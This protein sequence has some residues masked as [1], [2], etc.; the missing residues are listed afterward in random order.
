MSNSIFKYIVWSRNRRLYFPP[1]GFLAARLQL[2]FNQESWQEP[3][4]QFSINGACRFWIAFPC[5]ECSTAELLLLCRLQLQVHR[6]PPASFPP[7]EHDLRQTWA[8]TSAASSFYVESINVQPKTLSQL[9]GKIYT[10]CMSVYKCLL[11]TVVFFF[12]LP[13]KYWLF[14]TKPKITLQQNSNNSG[15]W[16]LCKNAVECWT[17]FLK[18]A[19]KSG[20]LFLKLKEATC[21]PQTKSIKMLA[22]SSKLNVAKWTLE[23]KSS[24]KLT[25]VST[26]VTSL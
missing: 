11:C 15:N 24:K 10:Y 13:E 6:S 23:A 20:T 17:T 9:H 16:I 7:P 19:E 5:N 22:K 3:S 25:N 2:L 8:K 14:S 26:L 1:L 4:I 18:F 21:E 12:L